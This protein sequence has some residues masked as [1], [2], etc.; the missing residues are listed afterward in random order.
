MACRCAGLP[1]D[2]DTRK[3]AREDAAKLKSNPKTGSGNGV[4]GKRYEFEHSATTELDIIHHLLS[5]D[6]YHINNTIPVTVLKGNKVVTLR[7]LVD[8]GAL[9]GN[10]MSTKAY[11]SLE[12]YDYVHKA[13]NIRVCA[14]F[15][16]CVISTDSLTL[17]MH[18]NYNLNNMQ[19]FEANLTFNVLNNIQYD[20]I[21]GRPAIKQCD[22]WQRTE[23]WDST[24]NTLHNDYV[25]SDLQNT[26]TLH[27]RVASR[28]VDNGFKNTCNG[29]SVAQEGENIHHP[30]SG[31]A[32]TGRRI[33]TWDGQ[34]DM[35]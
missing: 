16:D 31:H 14:A 4:K 2:N 27:S 5:L 9:Q 33:R 8:T 6:T 7:A 17:D 11:S 20:L 1:T 13:I 25:A 24:V 18:F 23:L 15:N 28:V 22:I 26:S 32:R 30:S 34:A 10:Y 21:I 35:Q 29:L 19:T 12:G 3:K